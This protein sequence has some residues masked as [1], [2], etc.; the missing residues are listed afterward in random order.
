[1]LR[2]DD[3]L[4]FGLLVAIAA[5]LVVAGIAPYDRRVFALEVV[6]WVVLLSGL[7]A[8]HRRFPLTPV[9]HVAVAALCLLLVIVAHFTS[10]D[11]ARFRSCRWW[12]W[13]GRRSTRSWSGGSP[14][15]WAGQRPNSSP[16]KA[17]SGIRRPT[18]SWVSSGARSGSSAW[19]GCR[20]V[21]CGAGVSSASRELAV[22]PGRIT[23]RR[24]GLIRG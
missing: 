9:S 10:A 17:T 16:C 6:P 14:S 24:G 11:G 23:N 20:T 15:Q 4:A 12:C 2:T 1:M 22:A 18:C 8:V 21:R 13:R 7:V 5:A 3:R 19:R